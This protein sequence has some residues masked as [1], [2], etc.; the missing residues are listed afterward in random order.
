MNETK[1]ELL[2]FRRMRRM[3]DGVEN[4]MNEGR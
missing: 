2:L 4:E 1:K 3:V